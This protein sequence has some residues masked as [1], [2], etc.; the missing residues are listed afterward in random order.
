MEGTPEETDLTRRILLVAALAFLAAPSAW[1]KSEKSKVVQKALRQS[2]R[3]E[4]VVR[5]QVARA[6]SGVVVAVEGHTSYV[7]TNQ[8]VIQREGLQ[9]PMSFTVV[10]ERP[11]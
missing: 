2:V 8:H 1:A 6:A 4:V 3:V 10:V 5:G 9:G 7:L 11:R